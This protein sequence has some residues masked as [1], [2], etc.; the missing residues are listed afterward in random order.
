M[1]K[2]QLSVFNLMIGLVALTASH[3]G[4][5]SETAIVLGERVELPSRVF[6]ETREIRVSIP[7]GYELA[8]RPYP[9]LYLLDARWHFNHTVGVVDYLAGLEKIPRMIVVGIVSENRSLDLTPPLESPTAS[10]R[11]GSNRGGADRLLRFIKTD[12]THYLEQH[13]RIAPFKLFFGHSLG[14]LTVLQSLKRDPGFFSIHHAMSPSVQYFNAA[15]WDGLLA[16]TRNIKRSDTSLIISVGGEETELKA[17]VDGEWLGKLD[18]DENGGLRWQEVTIDGEGHSAMVHKATYL[19]LLAAFESWQPQATQ[20]VFAEDGYEGLKQ[21]LNQL[22]RAYPFP[23]RQLINRHMRELVFA[24]YA[25]IGEQAS[26]SLLDAFGR[27][28]P[29][30]MDAA[31]LEFRA[32]GYQIVG[33]DELA[34]TLMKK[35]LQMNPGSEVAESYLLSK[36]E[37]ISD[38][39][40]SPSVM[41]QAFRKY[42]GRYQIVSHRS[43]D[44]FIRDEAL[45]V[46][47]SLP[48]RERLRWVGGNAFFVV[49]SSPIRYE[50]MNESDEGFGEVIRQSAEG[51]V[52]ATRRDGG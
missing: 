50:F 5:S 20:R 14:G 15:D 31:M 35:V 8:T 42:V 49:G 44:V 3:A 16:A 34:R 24:V 13:Y 12:L 36:D 21:Y 43:I 41:P 4:F 18:E 25:A 6:N 45:W 10:R 52:I 29:S 28:F 9:V 30:H 39:I 51:T 33:N 19:A 11:F 46:A 7:D 1:Q 2:R 26:L 22:S 32:Q 27:D 23:T 37:D 47:N 17:S 38:I 40:P 48:E